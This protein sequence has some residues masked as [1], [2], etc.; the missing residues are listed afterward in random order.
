[1][2][3]NENGYFEVD[4]SMMNAKGFVNYSITYSLERLL[5]GISDGLFKGSRLGL[6]I[7]Y[8]SPVKIN[9]QAAKMERTQLGCG[10]FFSIPL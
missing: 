1:M 2:I 4:E 10:L 5:P 6:R 7:S 3:S 8:T 9:F